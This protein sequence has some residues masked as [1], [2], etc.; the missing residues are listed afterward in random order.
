M[1]QVPGI[2][3]SAD[4]LPVLERLAQGFA[5]HEL[6]FR[7]ERD[8]LREPGDGHAGEAAVDEAPD[9]RAR[10]FRFNG[11]AEGEHDF[12]HLPFFQTLGEPIELEA[13]GAQVIERS[14][15]A[16]QNKVAASFSTA[17]L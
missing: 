17:R 12:T 9:E 4:F 15:Q 14:Q 5:V 1:A 16:A 7:S 6:H 3:T 2:A 13:F 11:G 10:G 8:A